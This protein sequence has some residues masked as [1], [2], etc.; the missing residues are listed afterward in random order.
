MT[1]WSFFVWTKENQVYANKV[2][3]RF[4]NLFIAIIFE[5]HLITKLTKS[6]LFN[7]N[8]LQKNF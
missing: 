6:L 2:W 1:F 8:K 5:T 7:H 4:L 3:T